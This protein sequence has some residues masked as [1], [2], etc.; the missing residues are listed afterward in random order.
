MLDL[1][2]QILVWGRAFTRLWCRREARTHLLEL[3]GE[4]LFGEGWE[5]EAATGRGV[6]EFSFS[7]PLVL[8]TKRKLKQN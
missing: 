1:A 4:D 7:F 3:V 8:E 6:G 2:P 5:N